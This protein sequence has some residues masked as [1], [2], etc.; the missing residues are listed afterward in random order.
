MGASRRRTHDE[1]LADADC[2][3]RHG[4]EILVSGNACAMQVL[5]SN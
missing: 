1:F 4:N 3:I 2:D 5:P